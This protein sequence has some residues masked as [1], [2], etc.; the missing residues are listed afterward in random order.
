[1]QQF[2]QQC[3]KRSAVM[4][5][6]NSIYHLGLFL[7][8]ILQRYYTYSWCTSLSSFSLRMNNNFQKWLVSRFMHILWIRFLPI[9]T[10][11]LVFTFEITLQSLFHWLFKKAHIF[12][13]QIIFRQRLSRKKTQKKV[14]FPRVPGGTQKSF[15]E[16]RLGFPN[17]I[18]IIKYF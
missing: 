2:E 18:S 16:W 1:M 9:M 4:G 13:W 7:L 14:F 11:W 5:N 15:L 10:I 17:Y 8:T 12:K 3:N 6:G